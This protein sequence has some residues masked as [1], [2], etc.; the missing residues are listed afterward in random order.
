MKKFEGFPK[1]PRLFRDIVITEKIDGTNAS[2]E[3]LDTVDPFGGDYEHA[4]ARRPTEVAGYW[5]V[6]LAGSRTRY[7]TPE[8]DNFGFARF[9]QENAEELWKLGNGQHFGEWWGSGIQRGYGL[10]NGEKRF[11]LFN[12]HRWLALDPFNGAPE[13]GSATLPSRK[14]VGVVPTLYAGPFS[15]QQVEHAMFQLR[16]NGSMAAPGFMRPEGIIVFHTG[17]SNALFKATFDGDQAKGRA[18]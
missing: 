1:I 13:E 4:I 3:I 7:V 16:H 14:V 17:G 2:V 11:S 15:T 6:M 12:V 8:N 18:A 5:Q 10:K 9:V